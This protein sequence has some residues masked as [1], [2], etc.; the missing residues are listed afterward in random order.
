MSTLETFVGTWSVADL[1]QAI[2]IS[3]TELATRVFTTI[4]PRSPKRSVGFSVETRP[5][6]QAKI[7]RQ[8]AREMRDTK[9]DT[10]ASS[11]TIDAA[12]LAVLAAAR[13]PL[14]TSDLR[15]QVEKRSGCAINN[16]RLRAAIERVAT[17]P[18]ART[19]IARGNTKSRTYQLGK[20]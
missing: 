6:A 19:I 16:A 18:G 11:K 4:A 15:V 17:A 2:G 8:V 5:D 9:P 10:A 3:V 20:R 1:A 13:E 12:V 7:D 14:K